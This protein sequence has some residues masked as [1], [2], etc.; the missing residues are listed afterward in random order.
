MQAFRKVNEV[1]LLV[2]VF[3]TWGLMVKV[4]DASNIFLILIAVAFSIWAV[5]PYVLLFFLNRVRDVTRGQLIVYGLGSLAIATLGLAIYYDG[6]F[7]HTDAQNGLLF[8]FVPIIQ[9]MSSGMIFLLGLFVRR[10]SRV[11]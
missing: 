5:G 3:A 6:F 11:A 10:I 8:I 9:W 4:G 2:A 1:I 7:V